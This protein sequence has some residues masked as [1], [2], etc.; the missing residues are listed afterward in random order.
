VGPAAGGA[1]YRLSALLA[2]LV[3]AA[4]ARARLEGR[5]HVPAHGPLLL[6]SNHTSLVDPVLLTA[7]FPRPLTFM[8]KAELF[9]PRPAGM[10]FRAVGAIPVRRGQP[11]RRA[12]EQAL[13]TLAGGGVVAVFA[14]GTRSRDGVL[15]RAEPGVGLLAARSGAPVLPVAAI[16]TER[17]HRAAGWLG[18]PRLVLRCG[19]TLTVSRPARARAAAYQQV[20]DEIMARVAALL[21]AARRG[22]YAAAP[23]REE[24]EL[25]HAAAVSELTA[26][27]APQRID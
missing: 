23:P 10:A 25:V 26:P 4:L 19:M 11:D 7:L 17:L 13:A 20:A 2:R 21:P 6:V 1:P 5:E 14:E 24:G 8:G 18:R 27:A 16:G 12:L 9:R 15:G 3:L 22:P